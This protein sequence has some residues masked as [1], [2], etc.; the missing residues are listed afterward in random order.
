MDRETASLL[1]TVA[2]MEVKTAMSRKV[3]YLVVGDQDLTLL[4][5]EMKSSKHRRAEELAAAGHPV[6]IIGESE[7]VQ[8]VA[9]EC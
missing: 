3:T 8:M 9:E 6:T 1:A 4:D 5:G 7:F 2:G